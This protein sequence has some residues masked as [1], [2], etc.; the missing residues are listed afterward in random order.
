MRIGFL[1]ISLRFQASFTTIASAKVSRP[2]GR[3]TRPRYRFGDYQLD[4]EGGFLRRGDQEITLR[5]KSF[6]VLAYLVERHGRLV[7][8]A[9]LIEAV[10]PDAAVTDNSLAQCLL[11]N[12]RDFE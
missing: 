6:A 2:V 5:A 3:E 10:W 7:T 11:E 9:E 8:K 4:L 12:R 1:L